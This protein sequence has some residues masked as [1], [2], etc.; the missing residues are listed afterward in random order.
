MGWSA[1]ACWGRVYCWVVLCA[2]VYGVVCVRWC[3]VCGVCVCVR[4]VYVCVCERVTGG[5][6]HVRV[7]LL[8]HHICIPSFLCLK[9]SCHRWTIPK[10]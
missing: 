9:P 5:V 2:C 10:R 3:G 8:S 4:C 7:L 1:V 6:R